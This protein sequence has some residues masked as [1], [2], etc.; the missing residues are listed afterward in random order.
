MKYRYSFFSLLAV[1]L[2]SA[3]DN[4]P[5]PQS[6]PT[7]F[8]D[9]FIRYLEDEHELKAQA[10][11]MEGDSLTSAVPKIFESG[12]AFLGSN[13]KM[14]KIQDKLVRYSL[15]NEMGYM[16]SFRFK[17]NDENRNPEIYSIE[18][19]PIENFQM[20][21]PISKSKGMTV[22]INGGILSQEE[23]MVFLF[24]DKHNQARTITVLGPQTNIEYRFN[25]DQ[26]RNLSL[27]EGQLY[28]VKKQ[29]KV[30]NNPHR[31]IRT[32]IEYYTKAID[33]LVEE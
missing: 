14:K 30:Q 8:A 33:V 25:A 2:F 1:V 23:S 13:M 3:C 28:L 26:L 32:E 5:A 4:D 9:F 12:V 7:I 22:V 19:P 24:N 16:G 29:L 21:G 27:G 31:S 6:K 17:F 18:M 10:T 20:K 15:T 11:F